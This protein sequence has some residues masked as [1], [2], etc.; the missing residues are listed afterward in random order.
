V[1]LTLFC[2]IPLNEENKCRLEKEV[3]ELLHARKYQNNVCHHPVAFSAYTKTLIIDNFNEQLV[4]LY[5]MVSCS[6]SLA[7]LNSRHGRNII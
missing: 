4:I 7:R 5:N 6:C 1:H 3:E 2:N